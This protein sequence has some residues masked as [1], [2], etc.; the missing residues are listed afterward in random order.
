MPVKIYFF[1]FCIY[2]EKGKRAGVNINEN[3]LRFVHP[4]ALVTVEWMRMFLSMCIV[5]F[6]FSNF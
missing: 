2:G 1:F 4:L 3:I 6:G 5:C